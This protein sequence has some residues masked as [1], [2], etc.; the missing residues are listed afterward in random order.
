M[1][2][3]TRVK[4]LPLSAG[5]DPPQCI[6]RDSLKNFVIHKIILWLGIFSMIHYNFH[7]FHI[8]KF[9]HFKCY[10]ICSVRSA[11][12][13]FKWFEGKAKKGKTDHIFYAVRESQKKL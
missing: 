6:C 11:Y 12:S 1:V 4:F 5:L 13:E 10:S 2:Y 9:I 8:P 7:M 3:Y